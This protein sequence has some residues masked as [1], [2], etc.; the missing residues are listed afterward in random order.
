[1]HVLL[2]GANVLSSRDCK[3]KLCFSYWGGSWKE[4]RVMCKFESAFTD[5]VSFALSFQLGFFGL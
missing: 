4:G 1:M 3:H 2:V 5:S